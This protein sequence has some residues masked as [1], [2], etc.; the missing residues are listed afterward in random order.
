M[1][2]MKV[3][4]LSPE[5]RGTLMA[6]RTL[7]VITHFE[8][9]TAEELVAAGLAERFGRQLAIT[10]IGQSAAVAF[11]ASS[12]KSIAKRQGYPPRMAEA[13]AIEKTQLPAPEAC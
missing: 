10:A 3:V 2:A 12:A 5:A 13:A 9:T 4:R 1:P 7:R 8:N 11:P 6:L